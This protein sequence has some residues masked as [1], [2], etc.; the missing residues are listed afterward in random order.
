MSN[1]TVGSMRQEQPTERKSKTPC[2]NCQRMCNRNQGLSWS[3]CTCTWLRSFCCTFDDIP[4]LYPHQEWKH[5]WG[6]VSVWHPESHRMLACSNRERALLLV[7][8][9]SFRD[10]KS[11][12]L[13][14]SLNSEPTS[15]HP[16]SSW[17]FAWPPFPSHSDKTRSQ[18]CSWVQHL[19]VT[20]NARHWYR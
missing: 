17:P 8:Q 19:R 9:L 2:R 16:S 12:F 5:F 1:S 10:K 15:H 20:K 11:Y 18:S 4:C 14:W 6:T 3:P 7:F 13:V